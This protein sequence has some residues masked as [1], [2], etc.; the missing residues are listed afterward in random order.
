MR[1]LHS[2]SWSRGKEP[3]SGLFDMYQRLCDWRVRSTTR[4]SPAGIAGEQGSGW[5]TYGVGLMLLA[6]PPGAPKPDMLRNVEMLECKR[7]SAQSGAKTMA[8]DAK[9]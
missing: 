4:I 9:F 5:A 3:R 2:A 8:T 6:P 1:C 7:K